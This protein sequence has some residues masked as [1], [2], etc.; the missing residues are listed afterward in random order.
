[1]KE[2]KRRNNRLQIIK[3]KEEQQRKEKKNIE[4]ENRK[5]RREI[6]EVRKREFSSIRKITTI[7]EKEQEY[8]R[9]I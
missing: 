9:R 1:M 8:E 7:K 6:L 2:L 4:E 3:A 5:L